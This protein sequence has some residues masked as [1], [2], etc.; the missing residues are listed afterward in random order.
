MVRKKPKKIRRSWVCIYLGGHS[1]RAISTHELKTAAVVQAV[2]LAK[3]G[4]PVFV[5]HETG[6]GLRVGSIGSSCWRPPIGAS[7]EIEADDVRIQ[8]AA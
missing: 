1:G 2:G 3:Q 5:V 8:K 6:Q 4:E 7:V